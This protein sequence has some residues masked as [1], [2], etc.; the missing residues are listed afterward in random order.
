MP[1]IDITAMYPADGPPDKQLADSWD[2]ENFLTA[3]RKCFEAGY[4]FGLPLG[5]SPDLVDWVGAMFASYGA[6]LVDRDGNITVNSEP[7]K[8]FSNGSSGSPRF[9]RRMSMPG[10]MPATTNT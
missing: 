2:W 5:V 10:T 9:C 4:P 6:E 1:G 8:S 7:V 3:A